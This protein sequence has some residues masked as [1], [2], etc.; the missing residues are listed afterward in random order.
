MKLFIK[1]KDRPLRRDFRRAAATAVSSAALA[2]AGSSAGRRMWQPEDANADADVEQQD[3]AEN[4]NDG[5]GDGDGG[6]GGDGDG[7]EPHPVADACSRSS[8]RV[9]TMEK[10]DDP[11]DADLADH[12][13]CDS[14]F[15]PKG[16]SANLDGYKVL[17]KRD[18]T[19][20][21]RWMLKDKD[22]KV[23]ESIG[24]DDPETEIED[25][26]LTDVQNAMDVPDDDDK[27]FVAPEDDD[28]DDDDNND[29]K[30]PTTQNAATANVDPENVKDLYPDDDGG[31]DSP[32]QRKPISK[33]KKK[34][35][36]K[37]NPKPAKSKEKRPKRSEGKKDDDDDD[38]DNVSHKKVEKKAERG[39]QKGGPKGDRDVTTGF[40]DDGMPPIPVLRLKPPPKK[41]PVLPPLPSLPSLQP[42]PLQPMQQIVPPPTHAPASAPPSVDSM[43]EEIII[44]KRKRRRDHDPVPDIHPPDMDITLPP[45]SDDN[46]N[47]NYNDNGDGRVAPPRPNKRLRKLHDPAN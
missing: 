17:S 24:V 26:R 10:A 13:P 19:G 47:G 3:G 2:S 41:A 9:S 35:K 44:R 25:K 32:I 42:M 1:H 7:E 40:A 33:P 38:D 27:A 5:D 30:P 8:L 39:D 29:D 20:S 28:D 11:D 18:A 4:N 36:S 23:T 22:G 14:D 6:G 16:D 37:A 46:D 21:V 43:D 12:D 45:P 31:A 34:T 15:V